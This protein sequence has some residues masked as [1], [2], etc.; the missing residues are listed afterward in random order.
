MENS[1]WLFFLA[2]LNSKEKV[3][4][5]R[6][7]LEFVSMAEVTVTSLTFDGTATNI[8]MAQQLGANF[9]DSKNLVTSFKHDKHRFSIFIYLDACHMLKLIR[10]CLASKQ[11]IINENDDTLSWKLLDKLVELQEHKSLQAVIKF[12]KKTTYSVGS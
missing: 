5:V 2:G 3:N 10:N 12:K 7:C 4:V 9:K 6:Q 1:C 11:T 8:D